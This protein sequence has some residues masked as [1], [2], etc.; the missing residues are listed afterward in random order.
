LIGGFNQ[1]STISD[2]GYQLGGVGNILGELLGSIAGGALDILPRNQYPPNFNHL[3]FTSTAAD[4]FPLP[5]GK[6]ARSLL[7]STIYNPIFNNIGQPGRNTLF[8]TQRVIGEI[9]YPR[10][11]VFKG[12]TIN[13]NG[14]LIANGKGIKYFNSTLPGAYTSCKGIFKNGKADCLYNNGDRWIGFDLEDSNTVGYGTIIKK[15]GTKI[16]GTYQGDRLISQ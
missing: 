9:K 5:I 15:D 8:S 10:G 7:Q 4:T 16:S 11:T 1:N 14:K 2:I 6:Q 3:Q 12:E 13:V